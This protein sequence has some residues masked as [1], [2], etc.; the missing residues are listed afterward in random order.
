M[1]P[2]RGPILLSLARASIA[3]AFDLS[4]VE[5][6]D[7]EWL[8]VPGASFVTLREGGELRG[9]VGSVE[10]RRPLGED[11]IHAARAAAF[12]DLRFERLERRELDRL[13]IDVAVL[14]PLA[15][16]PVAS[17]EEAIRRLVPR[18]DGVVLSWGPMRAL[19]LPK[20]WE[21]LPDPEEFLANLK[22]KAGLT[23]RFWAPTL[24]VQIFRTEEF[25][26]D[27]S[28]APRDEHAP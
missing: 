19:F 20:V 6:P 16:L 11:V 21:M 2:G 24:R 22:E 8:R 27:D 14:S 18:R 26:E 1:T 4:S 23:R 9:C 13:H 5:I 12:D 15:E 25:S 28:R 3:S 17:E 7:L 10:A